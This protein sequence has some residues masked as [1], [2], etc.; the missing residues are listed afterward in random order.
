MLGVQ[1]AKSLKLLLRTHS[2]VCVYIYIFIFIYLFFIFYTS[3]SLRLQAADPRGGKG[4]S[5]P[6]HLNLA[7]RGSY[8]L[9]P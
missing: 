6:L 9:G 7:A 5:P 2:H 4:G 3:K 1:V 8:C